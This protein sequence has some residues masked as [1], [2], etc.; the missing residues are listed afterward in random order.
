MTHFVSLFLATPSQNY[1]PSLI[2]NQSVNQNPDL[3]NSNIFFANNPNQNIPTQQQSSYIENPFS[4]VLQTS[5]TTA[6]KNLASIPTIQQNQ[7][8][9]SFLE[10]KQDKRLPH[11][12][13]DVFKGLNVETAVKKKNVN[14]DPFSGTAFTFMKMFLFFQNGEFLTL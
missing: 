12:Q 1:A 2:N 10:S 8:F 13:Q 9:N 14:E 7:F 6:R 11:A 4:A 5:D 3:L